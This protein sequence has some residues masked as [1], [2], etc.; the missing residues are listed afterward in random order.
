MKNAYT[1]KYRHGLAG[2]AVV[3]ASDTDEARREAV[4]YVRF[5]T[6]CIPGWYKTDDIVESVEPAGDVPFGAWGYGC[7]PTVQLE[8]QEGF[9]RTTAKEAIARMQA[10]DF[11]KC[12]GGSAAETAV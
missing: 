5:T 12:D 2:R 3:A 6:A 8:T 9:R 10:P 11:S 1:V 4:S 7:R